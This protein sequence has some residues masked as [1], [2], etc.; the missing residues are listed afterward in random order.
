MSNT[1]GESCCDCTYGSYSDSRATVAVAEEVQ[2]SF[3]NEVHLNKVANLRG[4][5]TLLC[6]FD[7]HPYRPIVLKFFPRNSM[8]FFR[9]TSAMSRLRHSNISEWLITV[10]HPDLN[11]VVY[12]YCPYRIWRPTSGN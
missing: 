7:Q 1:Q 6:Q 11:L 8:R 3:L 10:P 4:P 9:E 2:N 12:S 5:N